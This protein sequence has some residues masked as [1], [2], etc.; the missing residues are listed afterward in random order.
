[1]RVCLFEDRGT[2]DLE[3]L[4]QTRPVFDLLCGPL[5]LAEQ[6]I[7]AFPGADVGLLVRPELADVVRAE[8]PG[9]PVNDPDW[10]KAGPVVLVNGQWL[11]PLPPQTYD[12]SGP[13]V[14]LADGAIAFVAV[15]PR[16][17]PADLT[18]DLDVTFDHWYVTLPQVAAGGTVVRY[19]WELVAQNPVRM[20]AEYAHQVKPR[21][22]P[23]EGTGWR[24]AGAGLIGPA[25]MLLIDPSARI[26]PHTMFD[27]THGPVTVAA[28]AVVQSFSHLEGPCH[29]GP[30]THVLG[31]KLRGGTTLG[32]CCRVGGEVEASI[33]QGYTNKYHG[34]FL[35]HSYVGSWVN[36]GAGS[37]CSDL[38]H[39]YGPVTVT[40]AG[41]VVATGQTKV[42]CFIGDH[43]KIGL[44]CLLNTGTH[45]GA[46]SQLLPAGRLLPRH[47]PAFC[48]TALDRLAER[49]DL[50]ALL[51]T[52]SRVMAR[53][54]C[55]LTSADAALYHGLHA[56]TAGERR[57]ALRSAEKQVLRRSA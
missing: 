39:D 50:D 55:E 13:C 33:I 38:R 7:R 29:V 49:D 54:G 10:L 31:A 30:G 2:A 25:D 17:L 27:T 20:T 36:F 6:Q 51:T 21:L 43:A 56:R 44:G 35:G 45:A 37:Q 28:G 14:G 11:P 16:H 9:V 15:E 53:R 8:R 46:F 1:M 12:L 19:L 23:W 5:S 26:D 48:E 42:G 41:R 47:V 18:D 57:Q 40:V 4:S 22:G 52:A 32:P 34:G 24:P 3:P